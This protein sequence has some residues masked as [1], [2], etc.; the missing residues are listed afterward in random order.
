MKKSILFFA[1]TAVM[2]AGCS[3]EKITDTFAEDSALY[4]TVEGFWEDNSRSTEDNRIFLEFTEDSYIFHECDIDE[5]Q[6]YTYP[7]V[8]YSFER[9][10]LNVDGAYAKIEFSSDGNTLYWI[11]DDKTLTYS[12]VS[13]DEVLSLGVPVQDSEDKETEIPVE[14]EP[15]VTSAPIEETSA[16]T[17]SEP[18][19]LAEAGASGIKLY[20]LFGES[21]TIIVERDGT[22]DEF[23]Q[24]IDSEEFSLAYCAWQDIDNDGKSE[25]I[26]VIATE[27]KRQE[28]IIYK[29]DGEHCSEFR[30]D[31][32]AKLRRRVDYAID[33]EN[34]W[35]DFAAYGTNDIYSTST[36][37]AYPNGIYSITFGDVV[38][39]ELSDGKILLS[40]EP[41]ANE[42]SYEC[43]PEITAEVTFDG[44]SFELENIYLD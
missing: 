18:V 5:W 16:I 44:D 22:R 19:F 37:K 11:T 6:V 41:R 17:E 10:M 30:F 26:C 15:A 21:P 33:K 9:K 20:G 14:T 24:D 28:L 39:Y 35:L 42:G 12:K 31:S 4:T 1:L 3:E 29:S 2:L 36:A 43:M 25:I 7:P 27:E 38:S 23:V 13:R 34:N 32:A 8:E 40:A